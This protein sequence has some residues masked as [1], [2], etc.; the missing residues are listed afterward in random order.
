MAYVQSPRCRPGSRNPV[1]IINDSSSQPSTAANPHGRVHDALVS[2]ITRLH[3]H[4]QSEA[5]LIRLD[6]VGAG[7]VE[8]PLHDVPRPVAP[9]RRLD[10]DVRRLSVVR[11]QQVRRL[12]GGAQVL[13]DDDLA[14]LAAGDDGAGAPLGREDAAGEGDPVALAE[15]A[16]AHGDERV[17]VDDDAEVEVQ[18]GHGQGEG[19]AGQVGGEVILAERKV[20]AEML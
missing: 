3:L 9:A 11:L 16:D 1:G 7:R 12:D 6:V 20:L 17:Q 15:R 18:L 2:L 19:C 13:G 14:V 10:G 5:V 8:Q 4:I